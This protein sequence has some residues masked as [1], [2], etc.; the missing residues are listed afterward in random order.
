M[1][2]GWPVI[3]GGVGLF[4][5]GMIILTEGLRSLAGGSLR[6]L[7]SKY[8]KSPASGALAGAFT[9]ALIQSSSATIVTAVGFV[10]AGMLTFSQSLGII[11]GANIGTTLTGWLVAL[12]GFKIKLG[13]L[14]LPLVLLG[15]IFKIYGRG[16]SKHIGWALV[17][18]SL[19]FIGI[20]T[21]QEGAAVFE[22][23]IMPSMFPPDTLFGR[24]QLVLIGMAVTLV[25]QSSSAG[26][27][28]AMVA[29]ASGAVSFPQAAAM[30]IGMDVGTTFTAALATIGGSTPMRRTGYAHV[31]YNILTG[32]MAFFLL[33]PATTI[34][35]T[36]GITSSVEGS[37]QIGLALFHTFFNIVGVVLIL[38]FTMPFARLVRRLVPE[39]KPHLAGL[40]DKHLLKE[41]AAAAD[42]AIFTVCKIR[43][44]QFQCLEEALSHKHMPDQIQDKLDD[45]D[46]AITATRLYVQ[47][48]RAEVGSV[49]HHRLIEAM[50]ALDHL[51]RLHR[52]CMK[53]GLGAVIA[54]DWRLQRLSGVLRRSLQWLASAQEKGRA[55]QA[56]AAKLFTLMQR[57]NSGYRKRVMREASIQP[58]SD[59]ALL[60]RLDGMRW[61]MRVTYH[62][63]RIRAHTQ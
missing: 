48:I 3:L 15:V 25:T 17:G 18:F 9:T 58:S 39:E 55:D 24:L 6:G 63:W 59:E 50:H 49:E 31:I 2:A 60:R 57:Q 1:I 42:A 5:A 10:G 44:Q 29:L 32:V 13:L 28:T 16:V 34:L 51:R 26:V 8:T 36:I 20:A 11:F 22:G 46:R 35:N 27:A 19:L 43:D 53:D 47:E 33:G 41:P 54:K 14:A 61:L 30:V 4:L 52:R 12:L 23:M 7:L 62:L 56:Y 21:M 45:I 38:P 37:A 40:L